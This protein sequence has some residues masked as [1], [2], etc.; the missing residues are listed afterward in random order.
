MK[1]QI[2]LTADVATID[3]ASGKINILGAFNKIHAKKF[4]VIHP[5]MSLVIRLTAS[6]TH[7]PNG[8]RNIEITLADEDGVTLF[9]VQTPVQLPMLDGYRQDANI[10]MELNHLMFPR[11]GLYEF[12]V[13]S[14]DIRLGETTVELLQID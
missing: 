5:R 10:L 11:P 1:I 7:E 3:S 12:V 13:S 8:E 6:E 14:E 2:L 4:P 9:G